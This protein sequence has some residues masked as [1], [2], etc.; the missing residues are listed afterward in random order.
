[1]IEWGI[2]GEA[3]A[4]VMAGTGTALT[5]AVRS[6]RIR[7]GREL[8]QAVRLI[9]GILEE[10]RG[11]RASKLAEREGR[12]LYSAAG[13]VVA[14]AVVEVKRDRAAAREL[15]ELRRAQEEARLQWAAYS[16]TI[17]GSDGNHGGDGSGSRGG[18]EGAFYRPRG[19]PFDS[20]RHIS[21]PHN[22]KIVDPFVTLIL[23][24][25]RKAEKS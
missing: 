9:L 18:R 22:P 3:R 13:M 8:G 2:S 4:E 15:E 11:L 6:G 17:I 25:R 24:T 5:R 14:R 19:L 1:L 20:R 23:G 16:R 7:N 10:D 12:A 21:A